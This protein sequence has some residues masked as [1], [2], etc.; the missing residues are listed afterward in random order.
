MKETWPR[1]TGSD[2]EYVERISAR[3]ARLLAAV[4]AVLPHEAAA[5]IAGLVA[6]HHAS[7][8]G[9][10]I[11]YAVYAAILRLSIGQIGGPLALRTAVRARP[12]RVIFCFLSGSA[13]RNCWGYSGDTIRPCPQDRSDHPR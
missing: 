8:I 9:S 11:G 4:A 2:H 10:I 12:A 1:R 5:V 13:I 7:G 6:V 3:T